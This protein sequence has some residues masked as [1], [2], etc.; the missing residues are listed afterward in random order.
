MPRLLP[1]DLAPDVTLTSLDGVATHLS[2]AWAEGPAVL[3][4]Y[5]GDFCPM[6]NRYL[7]ALEERYGE[8]EAAGVHVVAIS[9]DRPALGL[10][11]AARHDLSFDVL[12][13]PERRAIDAFDVVYN[14]AEGHAE[15]AVFVV[16]RGGALVYE[17]IVSGA[18]GRPSV[19]DVLALA[20]RAAA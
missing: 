17:S 9:A 14:E 20:R 7:H 6:C 19:D 18:L 12:S 5:R 1:G 10:E 8:F 4:F 2:H 11:T 3:T 15:P 13:D 16:A